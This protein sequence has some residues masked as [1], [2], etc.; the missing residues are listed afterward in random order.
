MQAV[1]QRAHRHLGISWRA[2][3]LLKQKIMEAMRRREANRPL[4]GDVRIDDAYLGGERTGGGPGRG[5][6]NKV[7]FVAAVQMHEDRSARARFEPV[8]NFSFAALRGWA[9]RTL[10]P[11]TRVTSDGALGFEVLGR[12]GYQH[13]VVIAPRGKAGTELEPCRWLN[14]V[15]GN[16]KTALAGTHHAFAYRK[17]AH[18]YLAEVGYRFNRRYDLAAMVPRL[19]VALMRTTP[20]A[21]KSSW[22]LR[23]GHSQ[24]PRYGRHAAPSPVAIG[25]V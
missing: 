1:D 24:P 23:Q 15:L 9:Q 25:T 7:A 13:D 3:W 10:A 6:A 2:V 12:L 19:A 18:R 17:Y 4:S 20:P 8:E 16:L 14:V 21:R 11:G 5:S 22:Q